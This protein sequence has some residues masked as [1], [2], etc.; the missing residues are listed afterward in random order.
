MKIAATLGETAVFLSLRKKHKKT[1][2]IFVGVVVGVNLT[3]ALHNRGVG[4]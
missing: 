3:T 1:A 4:R 2:W